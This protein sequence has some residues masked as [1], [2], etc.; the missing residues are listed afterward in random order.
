M[1]KLDQCEG[2]SLRDAFD[3]VKG[4]R[5]VVQVMVKLVYDLVIWE[6][7][8]ISFEQSPTLF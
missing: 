6:P 4:A 3:A 8:C 7:V 5:S 1:I 2:M